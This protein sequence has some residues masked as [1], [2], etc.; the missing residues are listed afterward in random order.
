MEDESLQDTVCFGEGS[1]WRVML[2]QVAL[3]EAGKEEGLRSQLSCARFRV[4]NNSLKRA[5]KGS[6]EIFN[7]FLRAV[8]S[9]DLRTYYYPTSSRVYGES[10]N[11]SDS[12]I[13]GQASNMNWGYTNVYQV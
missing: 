3:G 10:M 2:W 4:S 7:S 12:I 9:T 11:S 6:Q 8:P 13:L 1:P 5:T